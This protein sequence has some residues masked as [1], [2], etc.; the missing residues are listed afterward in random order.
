V[1]PLWRPLLVA[2]V[3]AGAFASFYEAAV[4]RLGGRRSLV[5]VLFTLATVIL[6]LVPLAALAMIAVR[7]AMDAVTTVRNT[8]ASEGVAG[9]IAKAPDSIEGYLRR[10]ETLLAQ[11]PSQAQDA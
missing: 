1:W 11:G 6:I 10:L 9:L 3:L 5:A 8:V 7:E 4:R 2:A